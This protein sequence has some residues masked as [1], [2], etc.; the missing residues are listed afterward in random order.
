MTTPPPA[1]PLPELLDKAL[2]KGRAF[3]RAH[4]RVVIA[5]VIV[6]ALF[7]GL[8]ALAGSNATSSGTTTQWF[9]D[10]GD[11]LVVEVSGPGPAQDQTNLIVP[12]GQ[13]ISP[14]SAAPDTGANSALC[15]VTFPDGI[16]WQVFDTNGNDNPQD[17]PAAI[18]C[19]TIES[20][21]G[22]S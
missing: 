13:T 9:N 15:T 2:D 1:A 8:V 10:T 12:D 6:L 5:G 3:C 16:T 22:A 7:I 21:P 14:Q 20:Q 18:E 19:Q 11:S 4:P 17:N